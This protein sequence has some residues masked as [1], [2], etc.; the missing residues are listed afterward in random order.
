MMSR[1][2]GVSCDIR[3]DHHDDVPISISTGAQPSELARMRAFAESVAGE[4]A[5]ELRS[6]EFELR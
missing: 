1:P 2:D 6:D 5:V 4:L 3:A